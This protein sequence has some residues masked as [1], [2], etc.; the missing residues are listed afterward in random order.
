MTFLV[1]HAGVVFQKDL[2]PRTS[3]IAGR[4]SLFNPDR[5]WKRVPDTDLTA[6]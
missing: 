3:R 5:T 2:G 6:K 4:I 1:N